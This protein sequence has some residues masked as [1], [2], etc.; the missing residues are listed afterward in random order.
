VFKYDGK[1]IKPAGSGLDYAEFLTHFNGIEEE[2][3]KSLHC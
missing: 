1:V 3:N 2:E